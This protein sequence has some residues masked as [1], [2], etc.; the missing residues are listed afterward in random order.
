MK[1]WERYLKLLEPLSV[2]NDAEELRKSYAEGIR[3]GYEVG[4]RRALDLV[5]DGLENDFFAGGVP[6][7]RR[8]GYKQ[9]W[10]IVTQ[11]ADDIDTLAA[12]LPPSRVSWQATLST[13]QGDGSVTEEWRSGDI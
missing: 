7:K 6:R 5:Q 2:V 9:A 13:W 12:T 4:L 1:V 3:V 10:R 8:K 11:I